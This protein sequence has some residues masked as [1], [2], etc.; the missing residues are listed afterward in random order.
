MQHANVINTCDIIDRIEELTELDKANE[1]TQEEADELVALLAL[2]EQAR[3]SPDWE[4]GEALI[5][6]SYFTEYAKQL[7]ED[8]YMLPS[9][10][11]TSQWPY[12]HIKI[13]WEAAAAELKQD[14]MDVQYKGHRYWIHA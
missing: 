7:A 13:N 12:N 3:T 6:D 14:Y 9:D 1:N 4:Y 5:A 2:A 8:C 10:L 11:E